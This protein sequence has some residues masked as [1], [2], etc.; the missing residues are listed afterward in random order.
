VTV[1]S[2]G[3]PKADWSGLDAVANIVSP[4]QLRP[5]YIG[6]SQKAYKFR[7]AG[8]KEKYDVA[9]DISYFADEFWQIMSLIQNG[10]AR[11]VKPGS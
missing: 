11:G 2:G 3:T 10:F 9:G 7:T 6:D 4:L 1:R 5:T 8:L